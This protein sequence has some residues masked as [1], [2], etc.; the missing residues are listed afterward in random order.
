MKMIPKKSI[1]NRYKKMIIY[2]SII[3]KRMKLFLI[4]LNKILMYKFN[5]FIKN[6]KINH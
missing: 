5:K 1:Y 6:F 3:L 2:K 4:I